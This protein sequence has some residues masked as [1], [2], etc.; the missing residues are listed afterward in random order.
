VW[1]DQVG[2]GEDDALLST[3]RQGAQAAM[4]GL[5]TPTEEG[6]T[7]AELYRFLYSG[8]PA[9]QTM[10]AAAAGQPGPVAPWRQD[11]MPQGMPQQQLQ[12][13]PASSS[14][15]CMGQQQHQQMYPSAGYSWAPQDAAAG[16]A[17]LQM[18]QQQQQQSAG[19]MVPPP[20]MHYSQP[21]LQQPMH[22]LSKLSRTVSGFD[23]AP[24]AAASML[25][26]S[27][28]DAMMLRQSLPPP[29]PRFVPQAPPQGT[30]GMGGMGPAGGVMGHNNAAVI[31]AAGG[32]QPAPRPGGQMQGPDQQQQQHMMYRQ[33]MP[34]LSQ[35]QQPAPHLMPQE[36]LAPQHIQQQQQQQQ[37]MRAMHADM[38][39]PPAHHQQGFAAPPP[40]HPPTSWNAEDLRQLL[41][42]LH[43]DGGGAE[44]QVPVLG[45]PPALYHIPHHPAVDECK[46][47]HANNVTGSLTAAT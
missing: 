30:A 38:Q 25:Q 39:A 37:M 4:A 24:H 10:A 1:L 14:A 46:L 35:Q 5:Q 7:I 27:L 41:D 6:G 28:P 2:K 15:A 22:V 21:Q 34:V 45:P 19:R 23:S 9:A 12:Q 44:G 31:T 13:L 16:A 43:A 47:E 29:Q 33:H 40:S 32:F 8:T 42:I 18:Q 20:G 3:S 11:S 36:P 26:P 17:F